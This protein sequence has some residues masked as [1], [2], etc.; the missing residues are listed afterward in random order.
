MGPEAGWSYAAGQFA[1]H[2]MNWT[3]WFYKA[4]HGSGSDSWGFYNPRS[5]AP[6]MPNLQTDP[7]ETIRAKWSRWSTD[8]AFA[9]NPML[10]RTLVLPARQ[11]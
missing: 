2:G 10:Q 11:H 5:P 8:G 9:L 1:A 3:M 6:P 7:A 4:T